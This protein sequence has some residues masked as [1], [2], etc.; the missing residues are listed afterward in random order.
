V[1]DLRAILLALALLPGCIAPSVVESSGR[2]VEPAV[3]QLEWRAA[4]ASDFD[5]L[6]ESIRIEG[7]AAASL[8][9][10]YYHFTPAGT[11]TG[12]AL[13]TGGDAPEFQTLSGRWTIQGDTL[14]LGDGQ[15]IRATA[16]PGHLRLVTDGG[17]AVLRRGVVQ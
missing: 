4:T 16:A 11:Y 6:Y 5:G 9:R 2:A 1:N 12:A 10:V 3:E 15:P 7:D 13:V 14:D 17:V 8:W